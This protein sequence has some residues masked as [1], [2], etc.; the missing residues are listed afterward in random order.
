M[1]TFVKAPGSGSR[2]PLNPDPEHCQKRTWRNWSGSDR[3]GDTI[4]V[5]QRFVMNF[6]RQQ[7]VLNITTK[8]I[9]H[10]K[11]F[12]SQQRKFNFQGKLK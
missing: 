1:L 6:F 8:N 3:T 12:L 9:S 10:M 5:N 2:R 7:P 4:F 11:G